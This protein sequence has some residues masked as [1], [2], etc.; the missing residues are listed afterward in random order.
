[1]GTS[2]SSDKNDLAGTVYLLFIHP[3]LDKHTKKMM[4]DARYSCHE[5]LR[6]QAMVESFLMPVLKYITAG[7]FYVTEQ[8]LVMV[9]V[10]A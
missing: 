8:R 6:R 2:V 3:S 1:V 7:L 10:G 5:L 9:E 4:C